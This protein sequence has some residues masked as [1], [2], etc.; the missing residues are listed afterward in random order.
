V[1]DLALM[2]VAGVGQHD[3]GI[4]GL[5]RPQFALGGPDHGFQVPEVRRLGRDLGGQDDLT[6][7]DHHLRVV[8]LQRRLAAGLDR[9]PL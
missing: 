6:V 7:V 2:P 8:T 9:R 5:D 4:A 1:F 3:L